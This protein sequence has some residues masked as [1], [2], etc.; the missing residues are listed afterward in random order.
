MDTIDTESTMKSDPGDEVERL[1]ELVN[2]LEVQ[3]Q[4]LRSK[5]CSDSDLK[6]ISKIDGVVNDRHTNKGNRPEDSNYG[7]NTL[8][9]KNSDVDSAVDDFDILDITSVPSLEDEESW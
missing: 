6:S 1:Q 2:Q 8:K 9:L 4:L 7:N 5:H 3:N